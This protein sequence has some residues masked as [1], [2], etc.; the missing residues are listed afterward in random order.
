MYYLYE[1]FCMRKIIY[2]VCG[3]LI[4]WLIIENA[5]FIYAENNEESWMIE[6]NEVLVDEEINNLEN[7]NNAKKILTENELTEI[8]DITNLKDSLNSSLSRNTYFRLWNN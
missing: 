8:K 3:I 4:L 2:F 6:D 7:E 1:D 5:N